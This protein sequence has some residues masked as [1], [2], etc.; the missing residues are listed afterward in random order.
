M[1]MWVSLVVDIELFQM[2]VCIFYMYVGEVRFK[3]YK[4]MY[5]FNFYLGGIFVEVCIVFFLVYL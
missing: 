3:W 4:Y 1:V 5:V 2:W